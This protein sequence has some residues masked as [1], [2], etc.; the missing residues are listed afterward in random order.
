MVVGNLEVQGAIP[1]GPVQEF[2]FEHVLKRKDLPTW[3][4]VIEVHTCNALNTFRLPSH[5][6]KDGVNF[7]L[8]LISLTRV[9]PAILVNWAALRCC[10]FLSLL[11]KGA[12]A[13]H[14]SSTNTECVSTC[15]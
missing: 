2:I 13:E 9:T 11:K 10:C 6:R 3:Q 12:V 7:F 1:T 5:V 15:R 14:R 8:H 4:V